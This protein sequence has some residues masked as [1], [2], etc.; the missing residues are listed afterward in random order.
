MQA[1]KQ[2]VYT[3]VSEED[4]NKTDYGKPGDPAA[5][6]APGESGMQGYGIHKPGD[7]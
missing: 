3:K 5:A 1:R 4:G 7:D 2:K 6:P